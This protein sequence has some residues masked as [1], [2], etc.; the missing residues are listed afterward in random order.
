MMCVLMFFF[1][2]LA[3]VAGFFTNFMHGPWRMGRV[4][5]FNLKPVSNTQIR[6]TA[7][8]ATVGVLVYTAP[9][10][11]TFRWEN[12]TSYE[13][14]IAKLGPIGAYDT[15]GPAYDWVLLLD[16]WLDPVNVTRQ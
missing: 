4:E 13:Y 7:P 10:R 15:Y 5:R 14:R 9:D 8:P 3:N 1:L 6:V 11:L 2:G 16:K 12:G